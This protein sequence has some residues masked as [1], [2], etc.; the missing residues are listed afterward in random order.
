VSGLGLEQW[1]ALASAFLALASFGFNW[2][3]V[4]RQTA[5]Q[6]EALRTA[7]DSDL[8]GWADEVIETLAEAQKLCRDRGKL[9]GEEEFLRQ[10]SA[11]R[12]RI[13]ALL[14]RGRLFFPN[15]P[16]DV[17][18]GAPEAAYQGKRQPALDAIFAA[19]RV[20]SDV[21]RDGAPEEP[22]MAI[23]AQR[24]VFVS[25]IFNAVDPRRR[26]ATITELD[27]RRAR[28]RA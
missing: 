17:E 27:Y 23:V 4:R 5:M 19:Y 18:N 9:V 2:A 11:L 6:F 22:V 12:T 3:V 8:I 10:R 24:R 13:S 26:Q 7:H 20:L 16:I 25:E 14:D 21:G 1:V 15:Q 28:R